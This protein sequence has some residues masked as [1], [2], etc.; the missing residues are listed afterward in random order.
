ML[1]ALRVAHI[2]SGQ[3]VLPAAQRLPLAFQWAL[4]P[5]T[6]RPSTAHS[7]RTHSLHSSSRLSSPAVASHSTTDLTS[8]GL[9][10]AYPAVSFQ[11]RPGPLTA[12]E[13]AQYHRDGFI[14]KRQFYSEEE[15]RYLL[16]IA[17]SDR[18]LDGAAID[19]PDAGGRK[20]K[21]TVWNYLSDGVPDDIYSAVGRGDRMVGVMEQL[22]ADEV[23][24]STHSRGSEQRR[25]PSPPHHCR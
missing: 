12:A 4:Q 25:V 2:R 16:S 19:V 1:S 23:Y 24:H 3:R 17:K 5:R 14:V 15:M 18:E 10:A 9:P 20:S 11:Y 6:V 21:L 13:L 22:L 8:V 7:S